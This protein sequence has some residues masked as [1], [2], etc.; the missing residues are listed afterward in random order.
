ML[1]KVLTRY[2]HIRRLVVVADRG[3]LS[4]DNIQALSKLQEAAGRTLEF[5]LAVPGRRYGEFV[6]LVKPINQQAAQDGEE[7][8]QEVQ[9]QGHRL[10][11]AHNPRQAAQ[12]T[13][14]RLSRI[15]AL[16]Q[17]AAQLTG[18]LD[19]QDGRQSPARAQALRFRGQGTILP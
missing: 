4:L 14:D 12:Q 1:K 11:V 17:R 18:K 19:A 7:I 3:L 5:I 16:E 9:W 2:P 10:V 6:D 8:V 15:H 13:Q